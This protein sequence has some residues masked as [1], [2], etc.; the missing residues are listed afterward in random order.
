MIKYIICGIIILL[1]IIL[2][3]FIIKLYKQR[4][5]YKE[6]Y[7][8]KRKKEFELELADAAKALETAIENRRITQENFEAWRQEELKHIQER[9]EVAKEHEEGCARRVTH[10]QL[11]CCGDE[12]RAVPEACRG[13]DGGTVGEGC[14]GKHNPSHHII[15]YIVSFHCYCSIP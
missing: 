12:L 15:Y 5:K 2:L 7:I 10:L 8:E 1:I 11:G 13:F 3:I 6:E 9:E 4:K 14:N